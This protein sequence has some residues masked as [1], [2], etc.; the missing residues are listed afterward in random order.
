VENGYTVYSK[1]LLDNLETRLNSLISCF[2]MNAE[3]DEIRQSYTLFREAM[4]AV[5]SAKESYTLQVV[6]ADI[7]GGVVGLSSNYGFAAVPS[8]KGEK[9]VAAAT[10]LEYRKDNSL[11]DSV[12][13]A[14]KVKNGNR[15]LRLEYSLTKDGL[16]VEPA[17]AFSFDIK[18][19]KTYKRVAVAVA[20]GK[21]GYK[22]IDSQK[23]GEWL[24]FDVTAGAETYYIVIYDGALAPDLLWLW[25]TLPC[26]LV[27]AGGVIAFFALRKKRSKRNKEEKAKI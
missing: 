21:G 7:F 26:V 5:T 8:L 18:I 13:S 16:P 4:I 3:E 22:E 14:T 23:G 10:L 6:N 17:A 27:A 11:F 15:I 9:V 19:P 1:I 20:D 2:Y 12:A 25:I 24:I